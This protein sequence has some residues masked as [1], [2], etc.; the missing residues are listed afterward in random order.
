MEKGG[1]RGRRREGRQCNEKRYIVV[2][3]MKRGEGWG[4]ERGRMGIRV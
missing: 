4:K 3:G 2:K 1:A